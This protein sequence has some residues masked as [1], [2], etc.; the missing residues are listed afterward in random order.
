MPTEIN[1]EK[2]QENIL[3]FLSRKRQENN[4]YIITALFQPNTRK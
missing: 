2:K 4:M 3:V 1:R